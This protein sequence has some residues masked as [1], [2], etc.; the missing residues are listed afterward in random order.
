MAFMRSVVSACCAIV[1][2][3]SVGGED[4]LTRAAGLQSHSGV[5]DI[6]PGETTQDYLG[7]YGI[8]VDE[9]FATTEDGY[10]LRAYRLK[11]AG[12]PVVLLQH[13]VL[14]SS[15]CWIFNVPERSLGMVLYKAGY[16]V[17]MTNSRGNT[18]SRNHTTLKPF[19]DKAFWD[20]TFDDMALDVHAN[21]DM[22]LKETGKSTLTYVGWSQGTTQMFIAAT[23]PKKDFVKQSVNLFVALSPVAYLKNQRSVFLSLISKLGIGQ[24][25]EDAFPFGFLDVMPLPAVAQIFCKL[26]LGALCSFSVDVFCGTSKLDDPQAVT[27][28]TAHFPAGT[29]VKDGNHFSQLITSGKFRRYDYGSAGNMDHYHSTS[30]PDYDLSSLDVPTALFVGSNDDLADPSDVDHLLSDTKGNKNIVFS[31]TYNDYSHLTWLAGTTFEYYDDLSGLL[32]RFNP[33]PSTETAA[34]L[35]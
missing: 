14:A 5:W 26:T 1:S 35:V 15:W 7:K 19:L 11:R 28:M 21:I 31:R 27:N 3:A 25:L 22:I 17:W 13:G 29:S 33:L 30:P 20:Y 9:H 23:G 10:I 34:L 8:P 32:Q 24:A 2:V 4:P 16:D 18:F 6:P 12:A